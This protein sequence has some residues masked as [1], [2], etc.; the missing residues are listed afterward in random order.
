[1]PVINAIQVSFT[2]KKTVLYFSP[3]QRFCGK[4]TSL[5]FSSSREQIEIMHIFTHLARATSQSF[6]IRW[7]LNVSFDWPEATEMKAAQL[8]KNYV[9]FLTSHHLCLDSAS[10]EPEID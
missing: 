5:L 9:F 1:M 4:V 3:T 7:R 6:L 8:A 2:K 10:L